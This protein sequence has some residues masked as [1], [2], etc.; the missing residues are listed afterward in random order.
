MATDTSKWNSSE[1]HTGFAFSWHANK[2]MSAKDV[3]EMVWASY[4]IK[5]KGL[6]EYYSQLLLKIADNDAID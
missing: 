6:Q 1:S 3:H 4:Q 2:W 5:D